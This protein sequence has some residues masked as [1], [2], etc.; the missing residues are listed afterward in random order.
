[1]LNIN[2]VPDDYIQTNESQRTNLM[3]L[4]L[5][6]IVMVAVGGSFITIRMRQRALNV[7]ERMVNEKLVKA[8]AAINQF[9]EL[10]IRRKAMMKTALTTAELLEPVPRSVLLASLTNNLPPGVSLLRLKLVQKQP[11]KA[12]NVVATTKYKKKKADKAPAAGS[13]VSP[14]KMLETHID[15]EGV[16]PSDRQVANYIQS[17]T[18]SSLL[19]DVSLVESKEYKADDE[20][21]RRFKLSTRLNKEVHLSKDDIQRIRTRSE[22]RAR[23]F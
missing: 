4:V 14:E 18:N 19:D 21:F 12:R 23:V 20:I 9:E 10:Q 15:I 7:K 16:A 17:L 11:K 22:S 5:L 3:Y 8:Q 2:F 13:S 1:M 6:A